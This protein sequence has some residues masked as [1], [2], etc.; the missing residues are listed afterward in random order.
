MVTGGSWSET[1]VLLAGAQGGTGHCRAVVWPPTACPRHQSED[2]QKLKK[3]CQIIGRGSEGVQKVQRFTL[4]KY[5]NAGK[6]Y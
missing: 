3:L 5:S 2:H 4:S 6:Q 1:L